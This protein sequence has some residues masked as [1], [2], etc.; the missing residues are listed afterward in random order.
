MKVKQLI[1]KLS[2]LDQNVEVLVSADSEGNHYSRA[3]DICSSK[4]LKFSIE[5]GDLELIDSEDVEE[6]Y[7]TEAKYKRAK[8]C[9]IIYP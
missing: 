9:I 6:G 1:K 2:K 3:I 5:D 8:K 4:G 7:F